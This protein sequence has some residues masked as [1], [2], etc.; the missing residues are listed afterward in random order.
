MS[1]SFS[2]P[3]PPAFGLAVSSMPRKM[4][5]GRVTRESNSRM[6]SSSDLSKIVGG[7]RV[8][9]SAYRPLKSEVGEWTS[10]ERFSKRMN[11]AEGCLTAADKKAWSV[12]RKESRLTG[13]PNQLSALGASL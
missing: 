5:S 13:E 7:T 10:G 12:R 1:S 6:A 11:R 8:C 3:S 2:S 4:R 9:T